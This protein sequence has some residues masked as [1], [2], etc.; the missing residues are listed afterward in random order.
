MK[1][2]AASS[3]QAETHNEAVPTRVL[4]RAALVAICL[5][6]ATV[7]VVIYASEVRLHR[8]FVASKDPRRCPSALAELRG[9]DSRLN[10]SVSRD[11][12]IAGCLLRTRHPAEADRVFARTVAREPN[13]S[14][15]WYALS[16][17]EVGRGRRAAAVAAYRH[18]RRLDPNLPPHPEILAR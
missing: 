11:I 9:W 13:Y 16:L 18:A 8:G 15:A 7:S 17:Y 3:T 1:V 5:L 6:G 10:P 4:V 12:T 2:G 14:Y